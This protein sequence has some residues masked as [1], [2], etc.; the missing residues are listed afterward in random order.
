[1]LPRAVRATATFTASGPVLWDWLATHGDGR[2]LAEV[3]DEA[4]QECVATV[5]IDAAEGDP[6]PFVSDLYARLIDEAA[7]ILPRVGSG[8]AGDVVITVSF[9]RHLPQRVAAFADVATIVAG[10]PAPRP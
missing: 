3:L 7:S 6:G 1:V 4:V 10:E 9:E 8:A 2:D 5:R